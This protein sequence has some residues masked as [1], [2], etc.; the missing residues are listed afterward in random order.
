[1]GRIID[2][3][4]HFLEP[5][6]VYVDHI[7][8]SR[9]D[10][11]LQVERDERGFD[12]LTHRGNVL[13]QI[14]AHVPG[15]MDLVGAQRRAWRTGEARPDLPEILDAWDPSARIRNLEAQGVDASIVFP[16]LGL[17]WEHLLRSDVASLSANMEAYNTWLLDLLP[18]CRDRLYPVAQLHLRDPVWFQREIRRIADAGIRMAMLAAQPVDGRALAH[19]DFDPVWAAFQ[20]LNVSVC[21]HVASLE[22][23]LNPAWYALDP[24]PLNKLLDTTFLYLPAAVALTSLI[25]HGK[26]EQFPGLRIGVTELS[27]GWVPG[28]LLHLDGAFAFYEMQNGAPLTRMPLRPSEYFRRQ[29]RIN[30]FPLEGA[31]RLAE[32]AGDLFAWG[33]DYP[34][35]EGMRRPSWSEYAKVQPTELSDAGRDALA[36]GNAAFLLGEPSLGEGPA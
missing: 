35:A 4:T 15:R 26:L 19:P 2:A 24:T 6:T 30:A 1:M 33:S 27:A 21:F 11:A 31:A 10:L 25:V 3:D 17:L 18:D 23:P 28:Y 36:G 14:D 22:L 29:V 16:N 32:M 13:T 12:W 5:P 34:H 20:D 9:R 7:G 8:A